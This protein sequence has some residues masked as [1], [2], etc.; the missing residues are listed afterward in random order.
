MHEVIDAGQQ[1]IQWEY[2]LRYGITSLGA[3]NRMTWDALGPLRDVVDV[4]L[5]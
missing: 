5:P 3:A 2:I 1:Y 4:V